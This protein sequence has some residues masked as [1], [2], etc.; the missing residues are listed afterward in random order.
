MAGGMHDGGCVWQ[1]GHAWQRGACMAGGVCMVEGGSVGGV[2]VGACVVGRHAWQGDM[3]G[4]GACMAR[5]CV[6][7]GACMPCT[8]HGHHE[9]WSVNARVVRIL[10]GC[11]LVSCGVSIKFMPYWVGSGLTRLIGRQCFVLVTHI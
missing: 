3:H 9:I 8:P 4:R 11:I 7:R 5:G 10:L 1:G 2:H 6:C